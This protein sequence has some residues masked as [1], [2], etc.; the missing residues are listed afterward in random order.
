MFGKIT[1]TKDD[2]DNIWIVRQNKL[3]CYLKRTNYKQTIQYDF[4]QNIKAI[5][6]DSNNTI[7]VSLEK[8]LLNSAKL[9]FISNLKRKETKFVLS[10][11]SNINYISQLG[12]HELYLGTE[13]GLYRY[14]FLNKKLW[15]INATKNS[16]VRSIFVD[17]DYKVW[18]TTYEK[19][20]FLYHNSKVYSFPKDNNNYLYSSHCII[21]DKKGFFWITTNKG[22][23]QVTKK[24][25]LNY[26]KDKT[27]KIYYY[28]YNKGDGFMTNEFNGG[29]Q[30]CGNYLKNGQ[31]SFPSMNGIVFFNPNNIKPLLPNKE[32]FINMAV[33]DYKRTYFNDTIKLKNDFERVEFIIDYPYYGDIKNLNFE[34][35]LKGSN[36]NWEKIGANKSVS[37]T[38]M[39]PGNYT[40]I[41]RNLSDFNSKYKYKTI[42]IIVPAVF[43]QTLWFRILFVNLIMLFIIF[44]LWLRFRYIAIKS[45]KLEQIISERTQKLSETI[46]KLK[47]VENNLKQEIL[48]QKKL[49]QAISHDIRSPLKY[50]VLIG[51]YLYNET[52]KSTNTASQ[53]YAKSIYKTSSQLY[54]FTELLLEYSNIYIE[55]KN[56][57]KENYS[58]HELVET[59]KLLF[60]EIAKDKKIK[61]INNVDPVIFTKIN[62]R[63][64]SNIIHNL[65]DNSLKHSDNGAITIFAE[66]KSNTFIFWIKDTGIGMSEEL[67]NY[68]IDLHKNPDSERLMLRNYGVGL[69]L[70][71]EL[72]VIIKGGITFFSADDGGTIITIEIKF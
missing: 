39:Q 55:E 45:K 44:F 63:V 70:V 37:F 52:K 28:Y 35:K 72:L 25:L 34:A 30:P 67:I 69:H 66:I 13:K 54:S 49:I 7:W 23:F 57:E 26:T 1:I 22:L 11:K 6:K 38:T 51:K 48:Q 10:A 8:N 40:L 3:L 53:K 31:I 61:I 71:L 21:E 68:Y 42:T 19:G 56:Y 16:N 65:L 24:S 47:K 60:E 17:N 18:F 5:Y 12:K 59:K 14:D 64:I 36:S 15:Y 20:F 43:Y 2:N 50:I 9:Y 33:V 41:V 62:F 4:N 58:F 29:C 46:A 27:R 32:L